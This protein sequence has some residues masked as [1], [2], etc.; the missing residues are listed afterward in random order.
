M[1]TLLLGLLLVSTG[2]LAGWDGQ[3]PNSG[4]YS[5][6][7]VDNTGVLVVRDTVT[8][9][10]YIGRDGSNS[11]FTLVVGTCKIDEAKH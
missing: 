3:Y 7:R 5:I 8:G 10:E 4:R 6:M 9:C 1:K 11:G 2:V